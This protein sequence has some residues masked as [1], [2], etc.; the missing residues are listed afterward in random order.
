MNFL[1][2]LIKKITILLK[3]FSIIQ[4]KEESKPSK[5]RNIHTESGNYSERVKG[6]YIQGDVVKNTYF[7]NERAAKKIDD[8]ARLK[9]QQLPYPQALDK[10]V[11]GNIVYDEHKFDGKLAIIAIEL[12]Q[13]NYSKKFCIKL[14][15]SFGTYEVPI[16]KPSENSIFENEK[17]DIH[18]GIKKSKLCFNL[19]N[20]IMPLE[21]RKFF[22]NQD[23]SWEGIFIGEPKFP[24]WQFEL[25]NESRA[26]KQSQIL[27]GGL[28]SE[29]LGTLEILE[30]N[31]FCQVTASLEIS[32]NRIYIEI[33]D[34]DEGSKK[35]QKETKIGL[36]LKFLKDELG[37][38]DN[39]VSLSKVA[40]KYDP[41]TIS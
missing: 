26:K 28:T 13:I 11:V 16:P 29:V 6:D 38:V 27:R 5:K 12:Y 40:K 39:K 2:N 25:M 17:I 37:I 36:L 33:V 15:V 35:T 41:A 31:T 7:L 24:E 18:F 22:A 4:N 1:A 20:V 9:N 34:F 3:N 14:T 32:I 23:K 21:D 30:A 10:L 8:S 19:E